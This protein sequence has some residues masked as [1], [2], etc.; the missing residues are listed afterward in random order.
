MLLN[1]DDSIILLVD[2]QE[3]LIPAVQNHAQLLERCQWVLKL[4][5]KMEVPIL[6][7]EQYP[8][9]LGPTS[10]SLRSYIN[11]DDLVEKIYFSCMK[12]PN[13]LK[14]LNH[15]HKNQLIIMGM[16]AHVCVLQTAMDMQESGFSV[17]VVADAVS[18]RNEED[19][20][21]GLKRMKHQ[22]IHLITAEMIFFEWLRHA[23]M[24]EFKSLS[25]EFLQ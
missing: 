19:M 15:H 4:A 7:S 20:K 1:K 5:K 16:E 9:G 21:Y 13:Y 3:K 14:R 2:V 6:A 24:S 10:D 11:Q 8:K 22:G 18:S 17:Y 12:E 23:G 25:K